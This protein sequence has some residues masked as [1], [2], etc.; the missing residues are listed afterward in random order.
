MTF[1]EIAF[2]ILTLMVI[3][4]FIA[5]GLEIIESMVRA[6][7]HLFVFRMT[8]VVLVVVLLAGWDFLV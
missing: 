3:F 4:G 6:I 1:I 7:F 2:M 5:F 8:W